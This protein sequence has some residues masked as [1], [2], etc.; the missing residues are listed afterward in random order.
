MKPCVR[1]AYLPA[2]RPLLLPCATWLLVIIG[3]LAA[4][5]YGAVLCDASS[6]RATWESG[7][8]TQCPTDNFRGEAERPLAPECG[9]IV[10]DPDRDGG[11]EGG[12][13]GAAG[14]ATGAGG[15]S[16]PRSALAAEGPVF[17][18]GSGST[19]G[20]RHR[21]FSLYPGGRSVLSAAHWLARAGNW[22]A[23]EVV[24]D[25]GLHVSLTDTERFLTDPGLQFYL[26]SMPLTPDGLLDGLALSSTLQRIRRRGTFTLILH[27]RQSLILPLLEKV[28]GTAFS[29]ESQYAAARWFGIC[30]QG[31]GAAPTVVRDDLAYTVAAYPSPLQTPRACSASNS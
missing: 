21:A 1:D 3:H 17:Y 24:Y 7:A 14:A 27:C 31:Q 10:S 29:T 5:C 6:R 12:A 15:T 8:G 20:W 11:G 2:R 28:G 19:V 22:T 16:P 26:N 18:V 30:A 13:A 25:P 9:V 23:C 4:R